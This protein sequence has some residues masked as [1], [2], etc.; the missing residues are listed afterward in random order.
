MP[1][2]VIFMAGIPIQY[3]P[4]C[5]FIV[6]LV[7]SHP[8]YCTHIASEDHWSILGLPSNSVR[9]PVKLCARGAVINYLHKCQGDPCSRSLYAYKPQSMSMM[10]LN[11]LRLS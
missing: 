10:L 11:G 9:Q 5:I 6:T 8:I 2:V 7:L 3:A 4:C 1:L